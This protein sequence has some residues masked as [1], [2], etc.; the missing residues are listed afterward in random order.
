MGA[1][2]PLSPII[3]M[4]PKLFLECM[5]TATR[6]IACALSMQVLVGLNAIDKSG[7]LAA[8]PSCPRPSPATIL[9]A[10]PFE[11]MPI[12]PSM[13]CGKRGMTYQ[14]SRRKRVNSH[15]LEKR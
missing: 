11:P 9:P 8:G 3:S 12:T 6:Q 2:K 13:E 14:P 7:S 15:G 5:H 10:L 1:C 4:L